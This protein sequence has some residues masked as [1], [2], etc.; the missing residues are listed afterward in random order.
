MGDSYK[1]FYKMYRNYTQGD[2]EVLMIH[3]VMQSDSPKQAAKFFLAGLFLLRAVLTFGRFA[4]LILIAA[5]LG[6]GLYKR[7]AG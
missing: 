3:G 2:A 4:L 5:T 7:S 1:A 6:I